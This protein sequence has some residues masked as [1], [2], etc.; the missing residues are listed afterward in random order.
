MSLDRVV[1]DAL[2]AR[3][4]RIV[5]LGLDGQTALSPALVAGSETL[6]ARM[7]ENVIE[8]AVRHDQPHGFITAACEQ[9]GGAAR[10]VVESGGSPLDRDLPGVH[11]DTLCRI[12]TD[13]QDPAMI[14][15]LSAA[16][17][18][19]ERVAGLALCSSPIPGSDRVSAVR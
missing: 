15:M 6:L 13:S 16:G 4:N 3:R 2:A 11:G 14:L 10:L 17:T 9:R 1:I 8:N 5:E 12:I 7:V 18:P 19:A